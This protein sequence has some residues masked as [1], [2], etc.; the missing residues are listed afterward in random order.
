MAVTISQNYK[1]EDDLLAR[2]AARFKPLPEICGKLRRTTGWYNHLQNRCNH[3]EERL[4]DD[5]F[6]NIHG[7][8]EP[9]AIFTA[10]EFFDEAFVFHE[11]FQKLSG[12]AYVLNR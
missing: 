9:S 5:N 1:F 6:E 2:I 8:S 10:N 7:I 4:S 11:V 12:I 3:I